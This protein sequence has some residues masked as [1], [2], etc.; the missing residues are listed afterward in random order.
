[1]SIKSMAIIFTVFKR[2]K[3]GFKKDGCNLKNFSILVRI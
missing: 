3:E 1:M 2:Q